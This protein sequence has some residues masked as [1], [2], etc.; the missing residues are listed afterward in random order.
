MDGGGSKPGIVR[1]LEQ[2][3][4][5]SVWLRSLGF[6]LDRTRFGEYAEAL[7]RGAGKAPSAMPPDEAALAI[8]ALVPCLEIVQVHQHL[9]PGVDVVRIT[10]RLGRALAGAA[11]EADESFDDGAND[12]R[13]MGF[14]L[15]VGASLAESGAHIIL[16]DD[17]DLTAEFDGATAAIECKRVRSFRGV[18]K[19]VKRA[20]EQLANRSGLPADALRLV[21]LDVSLLV[22]PASHMVALPTHEDV[23]RELKMGT[24]RILPAIT[25]TCERVAGPGTH[26]VILFV[27]APAHVQEPN[28][29]ARAE[30]RSIVMLDG[31]LTPVTGATLE[32]LVPV[33]A[34]PAGV[35]RP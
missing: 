21:A 31:R 16:P 32:R 24:D 27:A 25:R 5:A 35:R 13:N 9:A 2:L 1:L 26:G 33:L 15:V 3:D 8:E 4:D 17:G 11:L 28:F 6:D 34:G 7:R 14:E 10:E 18:R 23:Q 29:W 30:D 12:A 19:R 22:R 20:G